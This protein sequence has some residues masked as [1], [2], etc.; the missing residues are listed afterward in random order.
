MLVLQCRTRTGNSVQWIRL[1][2]ECTSAPARRRSRQHPIL[3]WERASDGPA[4]GEE[5]WSNDRKQTGD[6]KSSY[7]ETFIDAFKEPGLMGVGCELPLQESRDIC[8]TR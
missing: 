7:D 1:L 5:K 4:V 6:E 8:A 2:G 3:G